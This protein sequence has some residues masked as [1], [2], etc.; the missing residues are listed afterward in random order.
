VLLEIVYLLTCRVLG[1]A[2]LVFRADR[3][4]DAAH[5]RPTRTAAG[6][7]PRMKGGIGTGVTHACADQTISG[8]VRTSLPGSLGAR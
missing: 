3:A 6:Q 1:L 2:V 4:K 7:A 8:I 5:R